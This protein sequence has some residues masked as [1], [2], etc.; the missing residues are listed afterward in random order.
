MC[1]RIGYEFKPVLRARKPSGRF[2]S[3]VERRRGEWRKQAEDRQP[4]RPT[5][6][7]LQSPLRHAWRVV[8]HAE[9]KRRNRID[10]DLGNTIEDPGIFNRL[11][12]SLFY[13]GKIGGI[14]GFHSNED[15]LASSGCN[16]F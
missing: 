5:A 9:D 14:E 8:V 7:F 6:N 4:R 3:L 16:Q 12:K 10:V 15:P 13:I 1:H 2:E 11:V